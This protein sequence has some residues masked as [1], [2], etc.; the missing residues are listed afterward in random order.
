MVSSPD[1]YFGKF[2]SPLFGLSG[3]RNHLLQIQSL[4]E[5]GAA[6]YGSHVLW[7]RLVLFSHMGFPGKPV[8]LFNEF[9]YS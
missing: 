3:N 4:V 8:G 1:F 7:L 5:V 9:I 2:F 6:I